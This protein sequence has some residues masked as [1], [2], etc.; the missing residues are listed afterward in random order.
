MEMNYWENLEEQLALGSKKERQKP[1]PFSQMDLDAIELIFEQLRSELDQREKAI[2][3]L[4]ALL[5]RAADALQDWVG[6]PGISTDEF[7]RAHRDLIA[8]LRKAA[9]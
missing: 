5:S 8:E 3:N 6:T 7:G 9:K 2:A 4:K 1:N